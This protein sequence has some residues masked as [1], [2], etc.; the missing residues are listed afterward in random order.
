MRLETEDRERLIR[1]LQSGG[2]QVV[3][4]RHRQEVEGAVAECRHL[5]CLCI[6]GYL[7]LARVTGHRE[8]PNGE[9][10]FWFSLTEKGKRSAH[11]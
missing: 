1:A 5:E 2:L 11:R 7:R 3:T 6:Y 10:T 8:D 4:Y 9:R